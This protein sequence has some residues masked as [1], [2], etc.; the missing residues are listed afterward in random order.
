MEIEGQ[1]NA[2]ERRLLMEAVERLKPET[3]L[4]VGTYLGGG[5]TIHLL[6]ALHRCDCGRLWGV[7]AD[8]SIYEKM[9]QNIRQAAPDAYGHFEPLFGFSQNVIPE[10]LNDH[11]QVQL[12][13]L[14]GGN[15]PQEQITEF[16]LLEAHIPVGGELFSHD[17]KLR[18]GK[19]L[20]PY[21]EHLDNWKTTFYDIS[22]E[23]LFHGRK[24]AERPTPASRSAAKRCLLKLK[25]QPAE[26]AARVL[27]HKVR[28]GVLRILP[29]KISR[30]L[31]DG[32]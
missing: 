27:P 9:I 4:E 17:V 16:C 24:I 14:D 10:R 28:A 3:V 11:P 22:D 2:E 5:S 19:W 26:L 18:K 6:K 15:N 29:S 25:L 8:Q 31:S 12:V 23:G 1:L 20:R 21:M 7:E 32:R 13:F 30:R